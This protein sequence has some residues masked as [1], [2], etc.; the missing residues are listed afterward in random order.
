MKAHERLCY[1]RIR[2]ILNSILTLKEIPLKSRTERETK[3]RPCRD[4]NGGSSTSSS[5]FS[6]LTVRKG[7]RGEVR[8]I[9]LA[10][11]KNAFIY[12]QAVA[13]LRMVSCP[14]L[15]RARL[16]ARALAYAVASDH[17][18]YYYCY[19]HRPTRS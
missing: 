12:I 7:I 10:R 15:F 8:R 2:K 11:Y 1:T 17:Y 5:R 3:L 6:L 18:D 4:K 13:M 16:R 19:H 9:V 14:A